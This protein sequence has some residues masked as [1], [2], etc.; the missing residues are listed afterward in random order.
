MFDDILMFGGVNITPTVNMGEVYTGLL[1][2]AL[3]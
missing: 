1:D 3:M 2:I